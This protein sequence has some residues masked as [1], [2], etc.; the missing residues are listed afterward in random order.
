MLDCIGFMLEYRLSGILSTKFLNHLDPS[1]R[2]GVP[3]S[4]SSCRTLIDGLSS[5]ITLRRSMGVATSTRSIHGHGFLS[6][7]I[8]LG[9]YPIAGRGADMQVLLE[10]RGYGTRP[11]P[12]INELGG[13]ILTGSHYAGAV[14]HLSVSQSRAVLNTN[15][16]LPAMSSGFSGNTGVRHL[17][18][19]LSSWSSHIL[20]HNVNAGGIGS[21]DLVYDDNVGHPEVGLTGVVHNHGGPVRVDKHYLQSRSCRGISLLPPSQ[22]IYLFFR[23]LQISP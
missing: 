2:L 11:R 7:L 4:W 19:W 16:L 9:E 3:S 18:R 22:R 21:L 13:T 23:P 5:F 10:R 8:C 14:F 20:A 1:V 12:R 17:Q 15:T 6:S